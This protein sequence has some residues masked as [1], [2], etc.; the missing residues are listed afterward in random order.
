MAILATADAHVAMEDGQT[1][2][3]VRQRLVLTRRSRAQNQRPLAMAIRDRA[4]EYRRWV[5][6]ERGM[7]LTVIFDPLVEELG[8]AEALALAEDELH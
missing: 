5:R 8:P 4:C 7:P 6:C 2:Q 3:E 1:Q